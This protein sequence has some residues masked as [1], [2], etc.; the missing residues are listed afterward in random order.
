MHKFLFIALV[1]LV[2]TNIFLFKRLDSVRKERD[3]LDS[4]Q[5]ALLSDVEHYKT[6]AGKNATSVLRL[7]LTK[8]EL[9]KKNKDLTKTVDDLNIKL[10]RIQA[11]TTTATKTEIEIETK[12]RDSIVYRNQLDTLLNFRWRDSWIDLRGTIDKGV[13][14]AKIESADT[15]HHIIHKIPKKFL[16]FRFGVKAIKMDVVNSNPHNK[17]TYTEYIELKK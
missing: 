6:E 15:L 12:V 9:E 17:I 10:K 2:G 14:F 8:N 7:E 16:F 11:A 1:L 13:L 5:A 3:R 4:N